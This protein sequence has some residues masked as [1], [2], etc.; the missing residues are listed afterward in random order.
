MHFVLRMLHTQLQRQVR[1]PEADR[2]RVALL[3]DEAHYLA[4]AE[5][6]VDQ[7]ATHRAAGLDVTFG[8]QYLAQ[9]GSGSEHQEK[10]RKGIINLLQSRFL[11]R[12]GDHEDAEDATRIAM[13]VYSTMIRDDP[14]SRARMRVTPEQILNLPVHF[15]LA[16]WIAGGSRAASFIGE[17]FP[18]PARSPTPG[19]D[20]HLERLH[21]AVGPYP[22]RWPRRSDTGRRPHDR[23]PPRRGQRPGAAAPIATV[24][25][26]HDAGPTDAGARPHSAHRRDAA[27]RSPAGTRGGIRH[28]PDADPP[29]RTSRRAS[30]PARASS[31]RV[32]RSDASDAAPVA[33]SPVRRV[34]GRPIRDPD[35]DDRRAAQRPRACASSR[36]STASTRSSDAQTKPPGDSLPR[37]Y[38]ADYAILALL[39]RAGL[40]LALA[41]RPRRRCP[42][43]R[44]R[45][46][47]TASPSSTTHGL[48]ARAEIGL[49]ERTSAD[50]RLPW[51]YSLTRHGL[52][53]AQARTPPAIHPQREW[54]ALEQRRAGTL[55]HNLHA[56]SWAIELHR[57]ARRAR[58]RLL[59]H[60]ALRHRPLPRPPDRQR[61]Q[62]PPDH[63]R[64]TRRPRR[65][66][67]PRPRRRSARS[68]PTSR[69]SCASPTLRLTFDL[70]VELDLTGRPVLQPRQAPRLR[71]LPHRL[72]AR[73]PPLPQHSAHA[74]SSSS[75]SATTAPRSPAPTK[76]TATDRTH[77]RDGTPDTRVVL[78]RPRPHL[79]RRRTRHPP[80]LPQSLRPPRLT[81]ARTG[82]PRR[83]PSRRR[84]PDRPARAQRH[85][86]PHKHSTGDTDMSTPH[87]QPRFVR[88][89]TADEA[90][91]LRGDADAYDALL[92]RRLADRN[93]PPSDLAA[94]NDLPDEDTVLIDTALY[95][96][97]SE[98][99]ARARALLRQDRLM[100]AGLALGAVIAVALSRP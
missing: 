75:S 48:I 96:A 59:A 41:D 25:S 51:L 4:S 8:L 68:S 2:P 81:A 9:L 13:A 32:E 66:R 56:L 63:R 60:P 78:R 90:R 99:T 15:C 91:R 100:A 97:A 72:G 24:A 34:V 31:P 28:R 71:R 65:P 38:D 27:A 45:P 92:M 26:S 76:P 23:S 20:I 33:D 36:S 37:L 61:P 58:H 57:V 98:Q 43:R 52:Q 21:D 53:T 85:T 89:R 29:H 22:E 93:E 80:R 79:L 6:V 19:R 73:P 35:A 44:P 49:R 11:F 7:I 14:D 62:T 40:V 88:A 46:S 69:S 16:S 70:L 74:P 47:A 5:N 54:R 18:F 17:T 94:G 83:R 30:R 42:A 67:H 1:R 3:A 84:P 12:L 77:R 86:H 55:P 87:P 50:G 10:I 39:D 64:R 95:H 82:R